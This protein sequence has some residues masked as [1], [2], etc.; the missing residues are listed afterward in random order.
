M[1]DK[2]LKMKLAKNPLHEIRD[3]GHDGYGHGHSELGKIE[4]HHHKRHNRK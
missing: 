2:G 3:G 1:T 4:D